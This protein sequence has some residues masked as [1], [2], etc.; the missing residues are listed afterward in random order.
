MS[1]LMT[2]HTLG[3]Q[4]IALLGLPK[5]CIS[6]ELR[7]AVDEI[8]TVKCEFYPEEVEGIDLA[9]ADYEL[10]PRT[11]GHQAAAIGFDA[12]MRERTEAAHQAMMKHARRGGIP[13]T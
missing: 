10:V 8:V 12:W 1:S 9:L 2:V 5:H 4:L 3:P 7:C 11:S 6:F 13:Y